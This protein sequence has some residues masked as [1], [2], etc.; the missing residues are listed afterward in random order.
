M[1]T[2]MKKNLDFL[3][4]E[5]VEPSDPLVDR[6]A[7]MR[8]RGVLK[9]VAWSEFTRRDMDVQLDQSQASLR[10]RLTLMAP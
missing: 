4:Y 3:M 7:G 9:Y 6:F 1:T 8:D 2:L 10:S 5:A